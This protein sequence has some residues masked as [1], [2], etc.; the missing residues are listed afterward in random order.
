VQVGIGEFA[1]QFV[2]AKVK[3][4]GCTP[5]GFALGTRSLEQAKRVQLA[6]AVCRF[7]HENRM[8]TSGR[9]VKPLGLVVLREGTTRSHITQDGK[10]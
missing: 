5:K 10:A 7:H 3:L 4:R 6:I 8:R 1:Q 2:D 9:R